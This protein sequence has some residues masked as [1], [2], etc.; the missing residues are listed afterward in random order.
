[1]L[2]VQ[3]LTEIVRGCGLLHHEITFLNTFSLDC[4]FNQPLL[5]RQTVLFI[6]LWSKHIYHLKV[7]T[8]EKRRYIKVSKIQKKIFKM[9]EKMCHSSAYK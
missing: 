1:M 6:A 2:P 7:L 9:F 5:N 3:F 8:N 4:P